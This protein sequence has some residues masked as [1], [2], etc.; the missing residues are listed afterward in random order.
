M[1]SLEMEHGGEGRNGRKC[2]EHEVPGAERA[3]LEGGVSEQDREG[4]MR[5]RVRPGRGHAEPSAPW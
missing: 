2:L 3:R 1:F 4:K 5:S